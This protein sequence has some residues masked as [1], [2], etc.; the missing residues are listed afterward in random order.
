MKL[1]EAQGC[2]DQFDI[3]FVLLD[4]MAFNMNSSMY[5]FYMLKLRIDH[6]LSG[7]HTSLL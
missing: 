5:F 1:L 6:T 2:V 4:G 3:Y 7:V